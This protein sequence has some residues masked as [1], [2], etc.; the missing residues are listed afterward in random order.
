MKR[1]LLIGSL[2]VSALL[3]VPAVSSAQSADVWTVIQQLQAEV[4]TNRQAL[5]AANLPLTEAQAQAYWPVYKAYRTE[6][7][8]IADRRAKLIVEYANK[9]D[10]MD[11]V[12]AESLAKQMFK[13]DHDTVSLREKYYKNVKKVLTP[14]K[15]ARAAQ[16]ENKL[17]MIVSVA[18]SS[19]LPLVPVKK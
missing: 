19:E 13:I 12:T 3:I 8:M 6:A 2:L 5:V 17:D 4:N 11:D 7:D 1:L 18:I 10:T 16:I 14:V 9:Y 15:A